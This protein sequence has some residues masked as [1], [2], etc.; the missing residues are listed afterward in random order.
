[1]KGFSVS[2]Y[3]GIGLYIRLPALAFANKTKGTTGCTIR[4]QKTSLRD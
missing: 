1:M 3:K 4:R 2:V